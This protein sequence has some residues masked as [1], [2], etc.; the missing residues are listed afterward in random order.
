MTSYL[1]MLQI[2]FDSML[3]PRTQHALPYMQL[4]GGRRSKHAISSHLLP[5]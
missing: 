4:Q 3:H 1:H 2:M 5:P